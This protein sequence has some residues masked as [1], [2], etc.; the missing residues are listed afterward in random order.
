MV[1]FILPKEYRIENTNIIYEQPNLIAN[2]VEKNIN[3]P[4]YTM[5]TAIIKSIMLYLKLF[6]SLL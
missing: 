3:M 6:L 5:Y 2:L 4:D 1:I